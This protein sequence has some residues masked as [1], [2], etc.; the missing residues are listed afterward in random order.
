MERTLINNNTHSTDNQLQG[1]QKKQYKILTKK[2]KAGHC[3]SKHK[4]GTSFC[5]FRL[6]W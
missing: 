5:F 1:T 2:K 6:L 3:I 4:R